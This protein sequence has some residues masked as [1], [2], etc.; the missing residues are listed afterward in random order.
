MLRAQLWRR[1]ARVS[2]QRYLHSTTFLNG[3]QPFKMPAMSPTMDKGGIVEWKFQVG[4][5]FNAGDV[6]L[7][8]ETDKAQIDVEAQDDGKF[9]AF[10][11]SNGSK[12]VNVGEVVA[13][14]AE[15]D[16]DLATLEIP[17]LTMEPRAESPKKVEKSIEEPVTPSPVLKENSKTTKASS[18]STYDSIFN[19]ADVNQTLLPSVLSLLHANG[20]TASEAISSIKAS[21]P[22][23]KLLK[24]DVL[25]H[26]GRISSQS[27]EKV[28]AYIK[29]HENLD[30]TNIKLRVPAPQESGSSK[31]VTPKPPAFEPLVIQ[32]QLFINAQKDVS[33]DALSKSLQ[34]YI[35]EANS[36]AHSEAVG[37]SQSDLFDPLFEDLIT[38]EPKKPR[39]HVSFK[40]SPLCG[41]EN[42]S[43]KSHNDI[44]DLLAGS[45]NSAKPS[46]APKEP[47]TQE[48]TL[49]LKVKVNADFSDGEIKAH[50][51]I[52]YMRHLE[53]FSKN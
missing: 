53:I 6:I 52:D 34:E 25:S 23:G 29:K 4:E 42:L 3:I 49:D 8:V 16:D 47:L 2:I 38:V 9:A 41:D 1:S 51:F 21:G 19:K 13:F 22:K 18:I 46:P 37:N 27:I 35:R 48:Y 40:L 43:Q 24:G 28:T 7:E 15:V 30:L 11:K 10:V 45:Y 36:I 12:D 17:K 20:I 39:F 50:R 31:D 33:F 26:L 32:E 44:F 5:P 14:I